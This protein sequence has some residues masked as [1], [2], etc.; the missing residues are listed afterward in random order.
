MATKTTTVAGAAATLTG[1]FEMT[2]N[3]S[4]LAQDGY[5]AHAGYPSIYTTIIFDISPLRKDLNATTFWLNG[6]GNLITIQDS[7]IYF[8]N[9]VS[10]TDDGNLDDMNVVIS[11]DADIANKVVCTVDGDSCAMDCSVT[12]DGTDYAYNCLAD[13]K[14]QPDWRLT[15]AKAGAGPGCFGPFNPVCVP[16]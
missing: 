8:A 11:S 3:A 4:G 1:P 13:P 16:T 12:V 6:D 2:A 14:F 10:P 5:Y 9:D 7:L 15:L